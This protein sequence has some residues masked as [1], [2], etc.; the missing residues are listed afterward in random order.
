MIVATH[1]KKTLIL[2]TSNFLICN[3]TSSGLYIFQVLENSI[4]KVSC[5]KFGRN[6][7]VGQS[8]NEEILKFWEDVLKFPSIFLQ[9][10]IAL[11]TFLSMHWID[12]DQKSYIQK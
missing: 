12:N 11:P 9:S 10:G 8:F 2:W 3:S 5:T 6:L 1:P 7:E 4:K